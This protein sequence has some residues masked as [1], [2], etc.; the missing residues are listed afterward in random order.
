VKRGEIWTVAGGPD[1]SGKPRPV[2]ILQED[3][4]GETASVTVCLLTSHEVDS[5][6]FRI[7]I[8][9]AP[10]TGLREPS[11]AMADKITTIPRAKLGDR[12][13]ALGAADMAPISKAVMTFLGLAGTT[14]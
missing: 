12:I 5:P 11:W 1:Y 8:A 9:P 10:A 13:G 4:F 6:L 2:L 7:A 3:S 14:A